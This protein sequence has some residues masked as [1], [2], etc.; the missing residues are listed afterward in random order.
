MATITVGNFGKALWP[1][2]NKWYGKAYDEHKV[3]YTDLFN[4]YNSRKH[5]EED[6]GI[7]SFGLAQVKGEGAPVTYDSERQAFVTRYTHVEYAL[8]FIITKI[9]YEDDLYDVV[10]ERRA[11]GLAFS[12]RQTK[13]VVGA[14]VYN[15][16]FT[17]AY[18][19]GDGKELLATDHPNFAGGTWANELATAADLSEAALEQAAI[20]IMKWTN[21]RGL[22]ISI[23]PQTLI[24]PPDLVFEAERILMSPYRVAT[25]NNDINALKAMGKFPG[26]IKVNHYLTD[27]DA[28]FIR[29][30]APDGMKY[31]ERRADSFTQDDDFDTENAKYKATARY[32]FGWTDPRGLFG[33]PGA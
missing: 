1:G 3:E 11:K 33:S 29:T 20:D 25:A 18:T 13:E 14:N 6:V 4:T 15:R 2:I 30:N 12:M 8:G 9:M 26:G 28:W 24:V 32:S 19:G 7:T 5:Y 21:D 23:M 31:F 16:A 10:G 22:K 27:A 17:A